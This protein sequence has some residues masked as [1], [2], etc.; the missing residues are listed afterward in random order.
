MS[1]NAKAIN[2]SNTAADKK[3]KTAF[4][5][6]ECDEKDLPLVSVIMPVYNAE[7]YLKNSLHS[8]INQ[9]YKKLEIICIND[10][11]TD[12]SLEILNYISKNDSRIKVINQKNSGPA[13]AR[14][15]GLDNAHGKYIS[16]VDADDST[17]MW[18]YY[19]L[20]EFAENEEADI[21]VFGGTPFPDNA[22]EW[23]WEKLSPKYA[24]YDNKNNEYASTNALF[25][26]K[27]SRPFIWLHFIKR[28]IIEKAP[29][30]RMNETMDL[31]ED[32]LFQFM[33]FPRA[34]KVIFWDKRFYFYRWYN[35]GSL[36]W[37]YNNKSVTK[38]KKH[39]QVV[40]NVF[41]S[42]KKAGYKDLYGDLI[43]WMVDFLYNDLVSFPHYMQVEFSKKIMDICKRND[44]HIFMCNEYVIENGTRIEKLAEEDENFEDM[45]NE[46]ILDRNEEIQSVEQEI[47][48]RLSSKSFKL[49][50]LLTSKKKRLDIKTVLPPVRK[51]N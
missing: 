9:T 38:F 25:R 33:Y 17:D 14:N 30:L 1:N 51:K 26:E 27:S 47:T 10:G 16:F 13:H 23:I 37:T 2:K 28:E 40:E 49:G 39:L 12:N 8:L 36:M 24:V 18:M 20:V 5:I 15:V 4:K 22:P 43:S 41:S 34:K 35:E 42:W 31:G 32:Q 48:A 45:M 29:K 21:M 19:S 46:I 3:E 50:R 44:Q 11:S 6:S 7:K